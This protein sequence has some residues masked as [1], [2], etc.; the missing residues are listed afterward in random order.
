MMDRS[1][2]D[3]IDTVARLVR[4]PDPAQLLFQVAEIAGDQV[5]L[6]HEITVAP[7]DLVLDV[8]ANVGVAA[9]FFAVV[10]GAGRVHSFEPVPAVYEIL[11]RNVTALAVCRAHEYGLA[12]SAGRPLF[13]YYAGAAAMSGLYA[14]PERDR[15]L[16]RTVLINRGLSPSEAEDQLAGRYVP[17]T[18][19]CPVRTLSSV[20]SE[21]Q[22][23]Y[24][25]L[26]KIDVERSELDVLGGIE[27]R[28]WPRI[29]QIV[30]ELHDEDGRSHTVAEDLRRRGFSVHCDDE[31]QM[32]GT[33]VRMLYA[34]RR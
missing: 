31:A 27:E 7:G 15:E 28:D 14:D 24:V 1:R 17:E 21:Q 16:V 26:L 8:G 10:C 30:I 13:T 3:R 34:R 23:E 11:R 9:V 22:I 32:R 5:Y 4:H 6:R 29:D 19:R 33:S 18:I 12:A 20:L 2:Q 25:N